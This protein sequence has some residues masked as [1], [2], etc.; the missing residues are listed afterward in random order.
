[1]KDAYKQ[2]AIDLLLGNSITEDLSVLRTVK[3][4]SESGAEDSETGLV[5]KEQNLKV[6]N[7]S[8][9][10]LNHS[11]CGKLELKEILLIL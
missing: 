6:D 10:N 4:D 3:T 7:T 9:N 1:M 2:T 8:R 11:A 5:E